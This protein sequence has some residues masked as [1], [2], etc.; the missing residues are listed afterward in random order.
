MVKGLFGHKEGR[1]GYRLLAGSCYRGRRLSQ[2]S[3]LARP[4]LNMVKSRWKNSY[5]FSVL[6]G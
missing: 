6:G 3:G 1:A 5:L 4:A 2:R